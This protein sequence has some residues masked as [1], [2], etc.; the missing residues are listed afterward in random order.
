MPDFAGSKTQWVNKYAVLRAP[1]TPPPGL[2]PGL[3]RKTTFCFSASICRQAFKKSR[4]INTLRPPL[5]TSRRQPASKLPPPHLF[6]PAPQSS[7]SPQPPFRL[8]RPMHSL[9]HS[10][11]IFFLSFF[12]PLHT[13]KGNQQSR[14]PSLFL[15]IPNLIQIQ[16][17][18]L[19]RNLFHC[20]SRCPVSIL[21]R[22]GHA[23][24]IHKRHQVT[25]ILDFS[26][27]FGNLLFFFFF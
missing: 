1:Q 9:S 11:F 4:G 12:I 22:T 15:A 24:V 7:A 23:M 3:H 18:H 19:L 26:L 13:K 21:F 17:K 8:D 16:S 10:F 6:I 5:P 14:F 25:R 2:Q 20:P 27:D